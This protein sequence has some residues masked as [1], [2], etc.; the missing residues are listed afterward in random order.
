MWGVFQAV[1][2][3]IF[4]SKKKLFC[5]NICLCS[6]KQNW[7]KKWQGKLILPQFMTFTSYRQKKIIT[8]KKIIFLTNIKGFL[9]FFFLIG[10]IIVSFLHTR[11]ISQSSNVKSFR[12]FWASDRMSPSN[13]FY[14]QENFWPVNS[15]K[16]KPFVEKKNPWKKISK[17][18]R[19]KSLGKKTQKCLI[20]KLSDIHFSQ[21]L[22][23]NCKIC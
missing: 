16:S 2:V 9:R 6:V 13:M 7:K 20:F 5:W 21:S 18:L 17:L 14:L 1:F 10:K 19:R 15:L 12:R 22:I 11:E 8:L 4:K 23:V 3:D